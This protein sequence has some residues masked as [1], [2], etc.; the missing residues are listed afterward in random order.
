MSYLPSHCHQ[1]VLFL[2]L[3]YLEVLALQQEWAD[4]GE[5]ID[6]ILY[7]TL[8][9]FVVYRNGTSGLI[10]NLGNIMY[11][12]GESQ[13]PLPALCVS[14]FN[15]AMIGPNDGTYPAL[16]HTCSIHL[17]NQTVTSHR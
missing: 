4:F 9:F 17:E 5:Y 16:V 11:V 8:Q 3:R 15:W 1:A 6:T 7:C 14:V 10:H 12:F 2:V 13:G